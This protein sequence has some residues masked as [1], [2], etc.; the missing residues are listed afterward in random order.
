MPVITFQGTRYT[1]QGNET[2]TE[3]LERHGV[4]APTS[5]R[6]GICQ[7]C[8]MRASEGQ[9]P[10]DARKDLKPSLQAK[11]YF[12]PCICKPTVDMTVALPD[13][14]VLHRIAATVIL[15]KHLSAEIIRLRLRPEQP[16]EYHAG[17]FINVG[18]TTDGEVRSYSIASL[19]QY[20]EAIE[21]HVRRLPNGRFST[22]LH[23]QVLPGERLL[24]E[25]PHG[26]CCYVP[27]QRQQGLLL[28]G[29][30]C[31]LSPLYGVLRDALDH[32]HSGAIH[33]FHGSSSHN[34]LYLVDELRQLA[35]A[36]ANFSYT[37]CVSAEPARAG[38]A[39]GRAE[40]VAL[41]SFTSL[42]GMRVYLC[43]HPD[44]VRDTKRKAFLAGVSLKEIHADPFITTRKALPV[45]HEATVG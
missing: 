25:G 34:G 18:R 32:G 31:G 16:L 24:I 37:P 45:S 35:H 17:Q 10:H 1:C 41:Q 33:L 11:N 26:D 6:S 38:Y 9:P 14:A 30:G 3:C 40:Q 8:M 19:P 44:M 5:C 20:N 21:I 29:T 43:G 22:W 27:E 39:N 23:D 36:Y 4:S 13:D 28:I 42:A 2:V 7:T 15:K 12:L